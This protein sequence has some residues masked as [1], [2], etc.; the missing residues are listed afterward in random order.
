MQWVRECVYARHKKSFT[1]HL[2]RA[3]IPR[4]LVEYPIKLSGIP[5]S[6]SVEQ[7]LI[8]H[9][10]S[11]LR[12][13]ST[14]AFAHHIACQPAACSASPLFD[15][16]PNLNTRPTSF[17]LCFILLRNGKTAEDGN[18]GRD[19][20]KAEELLLHYNCKIYQNGTMVSPK[21]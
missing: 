4:T 9:L 8:P 12:P 7:S 18:T 3:D 13:N 14:L 5:A 11:R 1:S 10:L 19:C 20:V 15:V 16:A 17:V 6:A 21:Q 2:Q